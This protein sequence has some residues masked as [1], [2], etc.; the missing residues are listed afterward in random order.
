MTQVQPNQEIQVWIKS[1]NFQGVQSQT[2]ASVFENWFKVQS[3]TRFRCNS[4][5]SHLAKE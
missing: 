2:V 3:R 4:N 1:F 5:Q